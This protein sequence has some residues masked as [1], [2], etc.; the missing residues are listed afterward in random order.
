MASA[1]DGSRAGIALVAIAVLGCMHPQSQ[2]CDNGALCPPG[3]R[4]AGAGSASVCIA[5]SCGNGHVEPGESCDDGNN[6]SGDG[7]PADCGVSLCGNGQIDPGEECDDGAVLPGDGCSS[8]CRLEA[9]GNGVVDLGESC[10]DGGQRNHDGCSSRCAI[11]SHGWVALDAAPEPRVGHAM[12]YD[13]AHD[14]VV[15]FGGRGATGLLRDTWEWN[16]AVWRLRSPALV[17]SART[18]HAMAYDAG[19]GTVVMFGGGGRTESGTWEW[20]GA[21]WTRRQPAVEPPAQLVGAAMA[22]DAG[23]RRVVLFG[24]LLGAA[25]QNATWEWDGSTWQVRAFPP[26]TALPAA[27]SDAALGFDP[28]RGTLVLF[29]GVGNV[30]GVPQRLDD[31]WEL[32]ATGWIERTGTPRPPAR[33][34]AAIAFHAG[35]G[36]L[37]LSGGDGELGP[38]ADTWRWDGAGWSAASG[39][40]PRARAGAT[41]AYDIARRQI[42]LFGGEAMATLLGDTWVW[43]DLRWRDRIGVRSAAPVQRTH[44]AMVYDP[45]QQALVLSGGFTGDSPFATGAMLDDTWAWDGTNWQ[46]YPPA[47]AP[48]ARTDFALGSDGRHVVLFGGAQNHGGTIE[49]LNDTWILTDAGWVRQSTDPT[50]PVRTG[51]AMAYD[52]GRGTLVMFG[53]ENIDAPFGV[54]SD[55]WEWDGARW[56]ERAGGPPARS[57]AAMA[58]DRRSG[59]VVMFG[60]DGEFGGLGDTWDWDGAGWTSRPAGDVPAARGRGAIAYDAGRGALLLFSGT[61]TWMWA[62]DSWSPLPTTSPVL[63]EVQAVT[64]DAARG[65]VTMAGIT[66]NETIQLFAWDGG[67]WHAVEASASPAARTDAAMVYDEARASVLLF[68]GAEIL[69]PASRAAADD[70]W[71]WDGLE[72]HEQHP[73]SAPHERRNT[74]M[75]YDGVR[76]RTVLFGGITGSLLLSDTWEWDGVNWIPQ[77][78]ATRPPALRGHAMVYDAAR[79]QTLLI[80]SIVPDHFEPPRPLLWAWDGAQWTQLLAAGPPA[81]QFFAA[82]YDAARERVVIFGGIGASGYLDDTWEW[83]GMRWTDASPPRTSGGPSARAGHTLVYDPVRRRSV[84]FGGS[85]DIT[86][87]DD[88]WEWDGARWTPRPT[89]PQ[90]PARSFHAM[91]YDAARG[92]LVMFGGTARLTLRDTWLFRSFDPAVPDEGCQPGFDGDGD[93]EI[94][95]RDADCSAQCASCGDGVCGPAESCRLCPGD[96]GEC[97]A[98]G[99]LLCDAGESCASCP[100]DCGSCP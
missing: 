82:A 72:W 44:V 78:P 73:E 49:A 40:G 21:T 14:A 46:Q 29:G 61:D 65:R 22:Y 3:T 69:P 87:L 5:L 39:T 30:A 24:G 86:Q 1:A 51:A 84:L 10:D 91:V 45:V 89:L 80:G 2:L 13:V 43:Q 4:C 58:Y 34:R 9:C 94:G 79:R 76:H 98:C 85:T 48:P 8:T 77:S 41:M 35:D 81:R 53:G 96:C 64:Y 88:Q 63:P 16:G 83:D 100:G 67:A 52:A 95:C 37:V 74:A 75:A 23:R 36:Q 11:E 38:L 90:P 70:T 15:L 12:A 27:R 71:T 18:G 33:S 31:T 54:L 6:V 47:A 25:A 99:D 55:T 19:R 28:R 7:C 32:G 59:H 50:P 93:G 20:D 56:T 17:P 97:G 57:H 66:D 62:G 60:G 92:G 42:V 68:G 26:A